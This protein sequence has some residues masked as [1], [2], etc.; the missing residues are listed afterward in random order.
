MPS[1][2]LKENRWEWEIQGHL[3]SELL[4][5]ELGRKWIPGKRPGQDCRVEGSERR[6]KTAL[7]KPWFLRLRTE[8]QSGKGVLYRNPSHRL[9]L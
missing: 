8:L 4:G 9:P 7:N 2:L 5:R 3:G 6:P 1:G